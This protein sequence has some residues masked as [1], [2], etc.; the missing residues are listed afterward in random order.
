EHQGSYLMPLLYHSVGVSLGA[1]SSEQD[2]I[3]L[4]IPG[5]D[6]IKYPYEWIFPLLIMAVVLL[7]FLIF[8]GKMRNRLPLT[9]VAKGFIPLL[10]SLVLVGLLSYFFWQLMLML[11]PGYLEMEHGFTYNGYWYIYAVAFL[12]LAVCF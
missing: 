4:N 8:F 10:L 12:T 9:A 7:I 2:V 5:F 11:Y 3:F 1:L 6:L